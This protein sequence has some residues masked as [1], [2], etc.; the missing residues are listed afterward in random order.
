MD[1]PTTKQ[2]AKSARKGAGVSAW[3]PPEVST[4]L[5][6]VAKAEHV[7]RAQYIC[8]CIC[9][10]EKIQKIW[11]EGGTPQLSSVDQFWLAQAYQVAP[12]VTLLD[13]LVMGV[14]DCQITEGSA[15]DMLCVAEHLFAIRL[16]L[17]ER[18]AVPTGRSPS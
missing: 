17:E 6:A 3:V 15:L 18:L 12:A 4:A 14:E 5:D 10:D 8:R 7:T 16:A 2:K 13:S 1:K 9:Q 11:I